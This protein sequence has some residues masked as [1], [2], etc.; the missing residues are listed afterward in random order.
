MP[1]VPPPAPRQ[2]A[3]Q[4]QAVGAAAGGAQNPSVTLGT[5]TAARLGKGNKQQKPSPCLA[6]FLISW[7]LQPLPTSSSRTQLLS[8]CVYF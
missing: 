7:Q 5:A 3:E 2:L 4:I 6:A 1:G 8:Q